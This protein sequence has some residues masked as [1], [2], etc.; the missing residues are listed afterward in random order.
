MDIN[1]FLNGA[2]KAQ[3]VIANLRVLQALKNE[4]TSTDY[5]II[6]CYEYSLV[7]LEMPYDIITLHEERENLR[8]QIREIEENSI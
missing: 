5:K 1:F 8:N 7:G 3:K 6:K 4:L 2:P